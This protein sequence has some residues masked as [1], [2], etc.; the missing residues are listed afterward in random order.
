DT[1]AYTALDF[2]RSDFHELE[3]WEVPNRLE[4]WA[5]T[6]I[7]SLV[8]ALTVRFGR[9]PPLPVWTDN[10]AIIGLKDGAR[11]FERLNRM[12]E[13]GVQ[14][15]G[16]WCEDWAGVRRTAFGTRLFWNWEWNA[17]RY[18]DLPRHIADLAERRIRFLAYAN[19]YLSTDGPLFAEAD[20]LGLF[21]RNDTARTYHLDFGGFTAGMVDFTNPDATRWFIDRIL[22]RNMLDFGIA[23]WMADFGEYLPTDAQLANGDAMLLHN[24]WPTLWAELNARAIAETGRTS[25]ALFFMRAGFT[26]APRHCPL[27]WGGDQSVDFSR[28]DGLPSALC[29]ALSS[30][31]MG[32]P[33]HHSD[34]GGYT[35]LFGNRRTPELLMR[36]AE[37]AAFTAVMRTHEGNRP[38]QNIQVD[39]SPGLLAHFARMTVLFRAL[40][41]Y[42]RALVSDAVTR[43]LPMQRA[44]CLEFPD[45]TNG[46]AVQD[47]FL[48]GP[49]LLV[50]PVESEAARAWSAYLPA[51]A[52]WTHLWS[53]A[54]HS[55]GRH[56]T[57]SAALGEP[58]VFWRQGSRFEEL[59]RGLPA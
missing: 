23:G 52:D 12:I 48:L 53:G 8:E 15:S 9:P 30:G 54:T 37:M 17:E 42:R 20:A 56:V 34:V 50:A 7:A 38:D 13:A 25:D 49:D 19:P 28:H 45:D 22:R 58:S 11:S 47:Q 40:A 10:G 27:L 41:P 1:S 46:Y 33:Y 26:G 36:W 18:P 59:F 2:R 35:S 29:A 39:S 43:G 16:L 6:D 24:A 57:V 3:C 14:V 32:N 44:L 31:L 55:G 51:G 4:L 21:V 5:A